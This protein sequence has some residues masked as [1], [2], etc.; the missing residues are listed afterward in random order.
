[1]FT[2]LNHYGESP[3]KKIMTKDSETADP[4]IQF[5]GVEGTLIGLCNRCLR[6]GVVGNICF[7]CN[8]EIGL[9]IGTCPYCDECG[10]SGHLCKECGADE[11]QDDIAEGS[12]P[13]CGGEGIRGT[14]CSGCEDQD[15]VYV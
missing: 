9:V 10:P 8:R 14:L 11:Y 1:M 15:M 13:I 4:T 2:A 6:N 5:L 7:Q 3:I 12:C